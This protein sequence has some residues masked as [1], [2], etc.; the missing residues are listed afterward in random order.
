MKRRSFV[1]PLDDE[2]SRFEELLPKLLDDHLLAGLLLD[3]G[4]AAILVAAVA[5]SGA[6]C[7]NNLHFKSLMICEETLRDTDAP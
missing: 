1:V 2:S 5:G 3:T 7:G 6:S 4:L